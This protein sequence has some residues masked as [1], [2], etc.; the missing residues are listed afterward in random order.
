MKLGEAPKLP[1]LEGCVSDIK[2]VD[3][4]K[5]LTFKL[6]PNRVASSRSQE[7]KRSAV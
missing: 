1:S 3:G 7:T 5:C 4:G 6:G 2:E